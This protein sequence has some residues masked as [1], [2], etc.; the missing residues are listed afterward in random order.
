MKITVL[1]ARGSVPVSG[2]DMMRF[3]GATSCVMIEVGDR[4]IFLDAGTGIMSVRDKDDPRISAIPRDKKVS[5]LITHPHA[6]HLMGLPFFPCLLEKDREIDIYATSKGGLGA[7]EQVASLISPPLW[8]CGPGDY[9]ADLRFHDL[10]EEQ[11]RFLPGRG[12]DRRSSEVGT[13]SANAS[14]HEETGMHIGS[15]HIDY[16][17]SNHPGGST[18]FRLKCDGKSLVYATDYEH[19]EDSDERLIDLARGADLLLYDGQYTPGEYEI[20]R[21][22]GHSTP[23][24]GV[25]IM[26]ECGAGMLRIVHHD[27][28]HDDGMLKDMEKEIRSGRES[29]DISFAREGE[30]IWLR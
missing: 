8:P 6:D 18:V 21:G 4:V 22:Y 9:P 17:E 5:V 16:M 14:R 27:P 10:P 15:M 28:H 1:G 29:E 24:H 23:E 30:I 25:Y 12:D 19:S 11:S 13:A 3:G 20:K 2:A 26:H 7:Y